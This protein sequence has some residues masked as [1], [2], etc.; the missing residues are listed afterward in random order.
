[1]GQIVR[2]A[3]SLTPVQKKIIELC[4]NEAKKI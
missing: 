4:F 1:M 3:D 2:D